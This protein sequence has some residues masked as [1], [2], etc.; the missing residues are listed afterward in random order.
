MFF[1]PQNANFEAILPDV[2]S[3]PCISSKT[4]WQCP[5]IELKKRKTFPTPKNRFESP[6]QNR[7]NWTIGCKTCA[8][9]DTS[10]RLC[11]RVGWRRPVTLGAPRLRAPRQAHALPAPH[12]TNCLSL[13]KRDAGARE[14]PLNRFAPPRASARFSVFVSGIHG[15]DYRNYLRG[16]YAL[17]FIVFPRKG[18]KVSADECFPKSSRNCAVFRQYI[19]A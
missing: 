10:R 12:S 11:W 8:C 7:P 16:M 19:V 6:S 2:K 13:T 9:L 15:F 18:D 14:P 4:V 17:N 5:R 3:Q 1:A